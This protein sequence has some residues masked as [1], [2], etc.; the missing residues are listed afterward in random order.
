MIRTLTALGQ[1]SIHTVHTLVDSLT[2][3]DHQLEDGIALN[4][5]NVTFVTPSG[6]VALAAMINHASSRVASLRVDMPL[7]ADCRR[8][9]TAAGFVQKVAECVSCPGAE[10][11]ARMNPT[12][13]LEALLPLWRLEGS[14]DIPQVQRDLEHRIDCMLGTGD[15][16]WDGA[17]QPILSTLREICENVFQHAG[18]APG[19]VAAQRYRNSRTGKNYLELA[20]GDAGRGIRRS[21]ATRY[22]ELLG[23]TDGV[24]LEQMFL[25]HL[26]R[27]AD[28]Y[29]GTGYY[30]LQ[31][32]TKDLDGSFY[33]RSGA[34]AIERPR[35][36]RLQRKEGLSAW[37]GTYLALRLTCG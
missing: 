28:Q 3:G 24:A 21:L 25:Q 9:L 29:H 31:K 5:A 19:W 20:I 17:K 13:G 32:A 26:T 27:S 23:A 12:T 14:Q 16:A 15:Q 35:R 33:L 7:N 22:T 2:S 1:L 6:I 34:G 11:L 18:G 30:V 36:G 37:P 8:Y 4:L 10:D